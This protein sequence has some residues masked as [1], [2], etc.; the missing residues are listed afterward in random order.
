MKP[1][2]PIYSLHDDDIAMRE[3]IE[4][5]VYG[6]AGHV[7]DLQEAELCGDLPEV[8]RLAR[9]L[10]KGASRSGYPAVVDMMEGW[11]ARN[12]CSPVSEVSFME[13]DTTCETWPGC[14]AGVE[15]T[16]CT[17]EGGGHC[18]FGNPSCLFGSSTTAIDASETLADMFLLQPL[19]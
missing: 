3:S 11:A 1:G 2:T 4:T 8:E 18:W 12:G 5:F 13:G 10:A 6:L 16:L 9:D 17:V 15:V 19:P 7:D 14:D